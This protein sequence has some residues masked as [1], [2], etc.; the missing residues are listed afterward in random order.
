MESLPPDLALEIL[1]KLAVQDPA[2][3]LRATCASEHLCHVAKGNPTLWLKAFLSL[4]PVLEL[5]FLEG[6]CNEPSAEYELAMTSPGVGK[7]LLVS[8]LAKLKLLSCEQGPKLGMFKG[9]ADVR[10]GEQKQETDPSGSQE[11]QFLFLIR[12]QGRL[13]CWKIDRTRPVEG[14]VFWRDSVFWRQ[15]EFWRAAI[16]LSGSLLHPVY[17]DIT[18]EE[19]RKACGGITGLSASQ[20]PDLDKAELDLEIHKV[21][22]ASECWGQHSLAPPVDEYRCTYLGLD[23]LQFDIHLVR[24]INCVTNVP[25][26]FL[27]TPTQRVTVGT[28]IGRELHRGMKFS[29]KFLCFLLLAFILYL[30]APLVYVNRV[31]P[32]HQKRCIRKSFRTLSSIV[33]IRPRSLAR[34]GPK[35]KLE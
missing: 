35:V 5:P 33:G 15:S 4:E 10:E 18:F 20:C 6:R 16:N 25:H 23:L 27:S 29:F 7:Q 30:V 32:I 31:L 34:P 14:D 21:L 26:T 1:Q 2:S 11:D 19:I 22:H 28:R 13:L 12:V 17:A 24:R 8:R 9:S 3:L